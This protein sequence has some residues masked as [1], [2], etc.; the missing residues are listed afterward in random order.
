MKKRL[1]PLLP[2]LLLALVGLQGCSRDDSQFLA[3]ELDDPDY[4]QG[5]QL[6]RQGSPKQALTAF[7]KVIAKRHDDAPESHLEAGLIC[8]QHMKNPIEA[9][10]HFNKYLELQPNSR[11]AELVRQRID[12]AKRDFARTLPA[13]PLESATDRLEMQDQLAHLQR[14]NDQLKAELAAL[15][16]GASAPVMRPR[17]D[18]TTSEDAA[19]LIRP[20]VIVSQP[21]AESPIS[22]VP[23]NPVPAARMSATRPATPHS[24]AAKPAAPASAGRK[25]TV[26][27]G[28][29]LY[30]IATHYYGAAGASA[31]VQAIYEANR[32]VMKSTSDLKPGMELKIP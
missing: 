11:Q 2:A 21:E 1:H 22:L 25:H 4:R 30:K 12:A 14:E 6:E 17:V 13:Q 10:Y 23:D 15:P 8:A 19:A 29:S 32:D 27:V 26:Q 18:A 20:P 31:K 9:I 24:N 5:Q 16:G 28:E 3:S 7:L